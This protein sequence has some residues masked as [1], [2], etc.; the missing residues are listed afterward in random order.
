MSMFNS[1]GAPPPPAAP[2]GATPV[3]EKEPGS[4]RQRM[5]LLG[6]GGAALV[7]VAVLAYVFLLSGG[8]DSGSFT[9]A[10]V[11]NPSQSTAKA[12]T[13][14]PKAA[15][16]APALKTHTGTARN[17]FKALVFEAAD[18]AGGTGSTSTGSTASTTTGSS[19]TGTTTTPTTTTPT[20]TAPTTSSVPLTLKLKSISTGKTGAS[21][22]VQATGKSAK[23]Y[24]PKL[25]A[26]FATYF[27]LDGFLS[28]AANVP[29][30]ALL[31]YG[32]TSFN[33]CK[34]TTFKIQ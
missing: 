8:S 29:Q 17:P 30:C 7:V 33:L 11:H 3:D 20:T 4:Q 1:E 14:K 26:T 19:T 10:F 15:P 16:A 25:G 31:Q 13:T 6:G 27:K 23:T 18:S 9:G 2:V 34:G 12:T 21:I 28:D 24:S 5:L 32:D 22:S